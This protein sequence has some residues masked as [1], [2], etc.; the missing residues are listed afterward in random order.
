MHSHR[1]R[2]LFLVVLLVGVLGFIG[3]W[4]LDPVDPEQAQ[5]DFGGEYVEGIA[6]VPARVNPL[7]ADEN[8]VDATLTSL[9][10]AGLTR[11]DERGIPFPVLAQTWT[12]SPDGRTYPFPL[13]PGLLWQDGTPLT[14]TDVI[15]TYGLLQAPALRNA[16]ALQRT[17]EDV[18]FEQ[19]S[20]MTLTV[21]ASCGQVA[22]LAEPVPNM[23]SECPPIYLVPA[24]T[25]RS[26]PLSKGR[27]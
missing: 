21:S 24:W 20:P 25:E 13:R 10:F 8:A 14:A 23:M 22:A 26:T 5:P 16:P 6:G 17:L 9:V 4:Y 15:F 7:Y 11:L 12:I 2:W 1:G 18:V 19:V 3:L 27:K